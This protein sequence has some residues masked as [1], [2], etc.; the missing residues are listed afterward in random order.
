[1]NN[2]WLVYLPLIFIIPLLLLIYT[3]LAGEPYS[4]YI[5]DPVQ[6]GLE[7]GQ[8][9]NIRGDEGYVP[10]SLLASYDIEAVV[11]STNRQWDYP[12]QLSKYDFALA[13]GDLNRADIDATISYGQS[14]RC[15]TYRWS[16]ETP[17]T[18]AYIGSHSANVHIIH[19]DQSILKK[20]RAIGKNDH[21]RLRGYLVQVDFPYGPWRSSLTLTDSGNGA[22]EIIYVTGVE[23]LD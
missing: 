20:V 21:I 2:R 15:Y 7:N 17:V 12:S 1:M 22:C 23:I 8:V 19:S 9:I 18:P 6:V 5:P 10:I 3:L 14:G 11:K 16:A 4:G 13:W